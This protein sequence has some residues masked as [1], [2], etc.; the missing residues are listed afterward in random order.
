M[1]SKVD[2]ILNM[3]SAAKLTHTQK[4]KIVSFI[5]DDI[6]LELNCSFLSDLVTKIDVYNNQK[7][8]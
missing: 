7:N 3:L 8:Y 6:A 1:E 4:L 5:L 2:I